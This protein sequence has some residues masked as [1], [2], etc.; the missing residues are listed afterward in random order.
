MGGKITKKSIFHG[1]PIGVPPFPSKTKALCIN[2]ISQGESITASSPKVQ[3]IASCLA[4]FSA[5]WKGKLGGRSADAYRCALSRAE[6]LECGSKEISVFC[7]ELGKSVLMGP[8]SNTAYLGI[9]LSALINANNEGRFEIT[10][11]NIKIDYLGYK[12]EKD[13]IVHGDVGNCLGYG[14]LPREE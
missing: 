1:T 14:G 13:I 8:K 3:A 5:K 2:D 9:F 12:N 7:S 6:Q 4:F 11:G 10:P